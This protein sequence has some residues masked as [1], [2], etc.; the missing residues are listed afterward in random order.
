M[1]RIV[2]ILTPNRVISH[3]EGSSK[4]EVLHT[5][6]ELFSKTSNTLHEN[7]LF[8]AFVEREKLGSTALGHGVAIPH[9]RDSHTTQ[10]MGALLQLNK[11]INFDAEDH[12][13]VDII[14]ALLVPD[15][16]DR[17]HLNLLA[18]ISHLFISDHFRHQVRQAVNTRS[19]YELLVESHHENIA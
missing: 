13:P 8:N 17:E 9:I 11:S 6:S 4:I 3:Y 19:L 15:N 14:F 2:N 1:T 12:Q 7:V 5:L 18:E 10:P 16:Q